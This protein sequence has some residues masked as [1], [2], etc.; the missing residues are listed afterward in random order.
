MVFCFR[1]WRCYLEGARV[2]LHTDHEPLTWLQTQKQL[3]RRQSRWVEILAGIDHTVLYV[4]GDENTVADALS[5][6]L[7]PPSGPADEAQDPW[8]ELL[9][10]CR[11]ATAPSARPAHTGSDGAHGSNRARETTPSGHTGDTLAVVTGPSHTNPCTTP[12]LLTLVGSGGLAYTGPRT[13][14]RTRT[15]PGSSAGGHAPKRRAGMPPSPANENTRDVS[16][17]SASKGRLGTVSAQQGNPTPGRKR[18]QR[19]PDLPELGTEGR[20]TNPIPSDTIADQAPREGASSSGT[21]CLSPSM[22]NLELLK[23][24]LRDG[25]ALQTEY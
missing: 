24:S 1:Q 8:P 11:Q 25:S 12:L 15:G 19:S 23:R 6:R 20:Y 3:N 4:K 5:R 7:D 2:F 10:P 22:T 9:T 21:R 18:S 16:K 13:R 14:S 17:R